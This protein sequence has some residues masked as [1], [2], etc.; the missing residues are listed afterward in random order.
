MILDLAFLPDLG[1]RVYVGAFSLAGTKLP[2]Y[3]TPTYPALALMVGHFVA[4]WPQ[5]SIAPRPLVAT[6]VGRHVNCGRAA[7]CSLRSPWAAHAYLPGEE[8]LGGVGL[9]LLVGGIACLFEFRRDH[10]E[11]G[12]Q[13]YGGHRRLFRRRPV[14]L[15]RAARQFASTDRAAAGHGSPRGPHHP[16]G[17]FGRARTQLGVLR[18]EN[19][20]A[21]ARRNAPAVENTG[22]QSRGYLIT[23][24]R[25]YEQLR[26]MLPPRR[27]HL[28][29]RPVFS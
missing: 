26:S 22:W 18:G 4:N 8:W 13:R 28:G 16:V 12:L 20:P 15:G 10:L 21:A 23:T 19:D 11:A 1:R 6:M 9:I 24:R 5:S 3:V 14:R 7:S 17:H 27:G 29:Q 25:R 2:S